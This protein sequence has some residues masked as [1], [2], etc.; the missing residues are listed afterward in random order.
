[1]DQASCRSSQ[2]ANGLYF[3]NLAAPDWFAILVAVQN[4]VLV[5]HISSAGTATNESI[6]M[7]KLSIRWRCSWVARH[8]RRGSDIHGTG[9]KNPLTGR[10][11]SRRNGAAASTEVDEDVKEATRSAIGNNRSETF[12]GAALGIDFCNKAIRIRRR[13]AFGT[14]RLHSRKFTSRSIV[15]SHDAH[16]IL[17]EWRKSLKAKTCR[18]QRRHNIVSVE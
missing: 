9:S 16:G 14:S 6:Q 7:A 8:R 4:R 15:A 2:L 1:M 5:L 17:R 12:K 11:A 13:R 18:K 3:V 10:D